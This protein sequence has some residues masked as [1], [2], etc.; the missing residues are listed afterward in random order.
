[1]AAL[2]GGL[3]ASNDVAAKAAE[4]GIRPKTLRNAADAIGVVKVKT[5]RPGSRDQQWLWRLPASDESASEVERRRLRD[6]ALELLG[7]LVTDTGARWGDQAVDIQ[8]E[9]AREVLD[10]GSE[11]PYHWLGRSRGFDKTAGLAGCVLAAMLTQA[12]PGSRLFTL[13]ADKDQGALVVDSVSGYAA[14]TPELGSALTVDAFKVSAPKHGATLEV[15]AADAPSAYGLRPWFLGVD[16]LSVWSDTDGPRRLLD[17]TTSALAKVPGARCCVITSAGDPGHFSYQVREHALADPLWRVHEVAGPPPWADPERLAE[18]RRRLL[19][20][21]YARLFEN[22]WTA[23]EDR[24]TTIEDVKACIGHTGD[25]D[26]EAGSHYVVSLDVGLTNDRT[27]ACVAHGEKR[28]AGLT[29]VVDRLAVWQGKRFQPVSL[30]IVEAWV[31]AACRDYRCALLFDPYQAQHVAQRLARRH[32]RVEEHTFTTAST[33]RLAV[34]L[35]RLLRDHLLDLPDDD[36]LI[37]ELVNVRLREVSPGAYRIDHASGRHDDMVIA[38]AMASAYLVE[39]ES[40]G[41]VGTVLSSIPPMP[42]RGS[43]GLVTVG[44]NPRV[45][46]TWQRARRSRR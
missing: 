12:P 25:L 16:E 1:V 37:D 18:Q 31:E 19:P 39:N 22:R 41:E 44:E 9:D 5:G 23:G 27:V 34:T 32:V 10:L 20:S 17:A 21:V 26:Y 33:G 14:R 11:T 13:A 29:V 40:R 38:V 7:G 45:A 36:A 43:G 4:V 46:N 6:A 2:A 35:Y 8:W 28:L 30:D 42:R 3:T 15:L 24:L